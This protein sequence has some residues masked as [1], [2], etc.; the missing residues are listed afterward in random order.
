MLYC[1]SCSKDFPESWAD[2]EPG[3]R[4]VGLADY[5]VCPFC[6]S[7]DISEAERCEECGEYFPGE[8]L[9]MSLCPECREDAMKKLRDFAKQHFSAQ[10][11]AWA[12]TYLEEV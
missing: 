8:M 11:L 2:I 6:K 12:L 5:L 3:D 10:R 4:S 1:Y 7:D 9:D